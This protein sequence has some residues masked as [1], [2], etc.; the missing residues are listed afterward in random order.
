VFPIIFYSNHK[1][2]NVAILLAILPKDGNKSWKSTHDQYIIIT[3][4]FFALVVRG[5]V[6]MYSLT[7]QLYLKKSW[8][9][10]ALLLLLFCCCYLRSLWLLQRLHTTHVFWFPRRHFL[11]FLSALLFCSVGKVIWANL[12]N[13]Q[14]IYILAFWEIRSF[15]G[16]FDSII[17]HSKHFIN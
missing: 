5:K 13:A 14:H 8:R 12:S 3:I 15:G 11:L 7:A 1:D 4:I 17:N 9:H 16:S 2:C 6:K 10:C